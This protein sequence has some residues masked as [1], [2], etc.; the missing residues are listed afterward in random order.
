MKAQT[1]LQPYAG[2]IASGLKLIE[3]RTWYTSYRGDLLICAGKRIHPLYSDDYKNHKGDWQNKWLNIFGKALCIVNLFD[4]KPMTPDDE[5]LAMCEI[6]EGA[7][8]WYLTDIR[9]INPIDIK[10]QLGLF[11]ISNIEIEMI[12][13]YYKRIK[14]Q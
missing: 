5:K 11:N 14:C 3:T 8:S 4:C 12:N 10:G 7:W 6:Y 13:P 2:W 9:Q 1:V